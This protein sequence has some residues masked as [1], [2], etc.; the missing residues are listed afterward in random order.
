MLTT[1][2]LVKFGEDRGRKQGRRTEERGTLRR[3]LV[4]RKLALSPDQERQ[5]AACRDLATLRRWHDEAI[6][7]ETAAEALR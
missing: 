2:V 7:A 1:Q 6:F 4:L 3:V 5:I